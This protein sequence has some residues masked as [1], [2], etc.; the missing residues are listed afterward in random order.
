MKKIR[1]YYWF[2]LHTYAH[3]QPA[4]YLTCASAADCLRLAR[5]PATCDRSIGCTPRDNDWD[6]GRWCESSS[7]LG[8]GVLRLMYCFCALVI[9]PPLC[10]K[11]EKMWGIDEIQKYAEYNQLNRHY[12]TKFSGAHTYQS[13][14]LPHR[15][16]LS[17]GQF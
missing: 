7:L 2:T 14:E 9:L 17:V 12:I 16:E 10:C 5:G 15:Q 1:S 8:S 6:W 3:T 4:T 11:E 13:N